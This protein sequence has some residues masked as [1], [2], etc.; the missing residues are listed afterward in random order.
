[1]ATAGAAATLAAT[2]D[3]EVTTAVAAPTEA[4]GAVHR[5]AAV[6]VHPGP[7]PGK[8]TPPGAPRR[9]GIRLQDQAVVMAW[10]EERATAQPW[11]ATE[12]WVDDLAVE[13][14]EQPTRQSLT[15][16]GI[17]LAAP[18]DQDWP[19]MRDRPRVARSTTPAWDSATRLCAAAIMA[20][21]VAVTGVIP[22]GDGAVGAGGLVGDSAGAGLRGVGD[23]LPS[24]I[25][26]PTGMTRGGITMILLL[27][28]FTR[29]LSRGVSSKW[30]NNIA[31]ED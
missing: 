3:A 5:M 28:T 23:G 7:G 29:M 21:G 19:R 25:G 9:A 22:A 17:P 16:S 30:A 27:L 6:R 11:L 12:P 8:A 2:A 13:A 4:C 10:P 14:Q 31:Q 15:G 20:A 1:M 26:P 18:A 24:G